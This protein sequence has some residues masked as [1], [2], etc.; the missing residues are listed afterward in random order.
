MKEKMATV[1]RCWR[2]I[3]EK[4]TVYQGLLINFQIAFQMYK[5]QMERR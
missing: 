5:Q 1:E 3:Q 2:Q 4:F